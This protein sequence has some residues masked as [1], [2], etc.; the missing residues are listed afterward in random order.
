MKKEE[1]LFL[2]IDLPKFD[3]SV[4]HVEQP[5][6]NLPVQTPNPLVGFIFDPEMDRENPVELKHR[7]LVRSHRTGPL[8][9]ELK[10]LNAKI[11]DDLNVSIIKQL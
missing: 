8:D 3:F 9:R 5:Y 10:P 2:Y 11:R 1:K 4:V 7:R 6:T